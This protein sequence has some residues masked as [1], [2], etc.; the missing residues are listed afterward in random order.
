MNLFKIYKCLSHFLK[1]VKMTTF[2]GVCVILYSCPIKFPFYPPC[3]NALFLFCLR[4]W[5]SGPSGVSQWEKINRKA[6]QR[7]GKKDLKT[8]KKT[9]DW[10][11]DSFGIVQS[12]SW[13]LRL[14][15]CRCD[16]SFPA[17]SRAPSS[18]CS[19][20]VGRQR[21]DA[22]RPGGADRHQL[23]RREGC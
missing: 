2:L 22:D 7:T 19:P 3:T 14:Y 5:R 16:S 8:K 13:V 11:I 17:L 9:S 4:S 15:Q 18:A 20:R 6:S 10:F 23:P 12:N 1:S 21:R